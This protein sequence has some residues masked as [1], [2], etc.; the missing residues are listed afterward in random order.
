MRATIPGGGAC[1]DQDYWSRG[2][3][4]GGLRVVLTW[5]DEDA[6]RAWLTG[7][8]GRRFIEDHDARKDWLPWPQLLVPRWPE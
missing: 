2:S 8:E 7:D 4:A 5:P 6:F 3:T 1:P